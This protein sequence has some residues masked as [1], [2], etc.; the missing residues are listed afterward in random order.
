MTGAKAQRGEVR[1]CQLKAQQH[2]L[3]GEAPS[4]SA[5]VPTLSKFLQPREGEL[6]TGLSDDVK[7]YF[8]SLCISTRPSAKYLVSC[9]F[10]RLNSLPG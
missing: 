5:Q 10:Q 6:V 9:S 8:M 2:H 1:K 4:A 7:A 3:D